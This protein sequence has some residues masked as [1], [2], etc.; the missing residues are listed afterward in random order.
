MLKA[1]K[2]QAKLRDMILERVKDHPA[3]PE[4]MDVSIKSVHNSW[5]V[6]CMP[7]ENQHIAYADC[8]ILM[9][10]IAAG[11]RLEYDLASN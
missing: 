11:L 7:P 9:T 4:G 8:C 6:D 5:G 10:K 3:C 1:Q 2:T